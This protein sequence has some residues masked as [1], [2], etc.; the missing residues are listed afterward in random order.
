MTSSQTAAPATGP[1]PTLAGRPSWRDTFSSLH[2]HNYRLYVTGQFVA[3]TTFWM[4]RI[5]TDWLVLEMTG[6]LALVGLTVAVQ[7]LPI[8]LF[9]VYGGVLADR[10]PKRI[11]IITTQ[12]AT[13]LLSAGLAALAITGTADLWQVYAIVFGVGLLQVVENPARYVFVYELVGHSRLTN[14]ISVNASI[15]HLG[16]LLG[17]ALAGVLIVLMG[18]G[19][20]IGVNAAAGLITVTSLLFMRRSE[21]RVAPRASAGRGQVREAMRYVAS[22]PTIIWSM[23]M[24]LFVAVFGMSLPALLAGVAD[25]VLH[26]GAQGYGLYSSLTSLGALIGALLSTRRSSLRLRSVIL[27]GFAYGLFTLAAGLAPALPLFL[28]LLVGIGVSRLLFVT[29]GESLTQ[30]SSNVA[31]RGRVMSIYM[32]IFI[33]GQSIGGPLI[34]FLADVFGPQ[35]ALALTGAILVCAS[36]VL[37]LLLAGKG[38]LRVRFSLE[39][40]PF[41]RI[42]ERPPRSGQRGWRGVPSST[43]PREGR[44]S[45]TRRR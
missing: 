24:L 17:P 7:C 45:T 20:A 28:T 32:M 2:S 18:A 23:V 6:S 13:V 3:N 12:S 26:S 8:L 40:R 27:S 33:G 30:L 9:G 14:A 25:S 36:A 34:G 5:A 19:W 11:T 37:G 4:K 31:I 16:G 42:A 44:R 21:L 39:E 38:G 43:S 35:L 22:K 41:A 29:A 1:I 10:L 15:F